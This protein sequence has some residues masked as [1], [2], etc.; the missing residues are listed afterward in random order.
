MGINPT[1]LSY[2]KQSNMSSIDI[3]SLIASRLEDMA[4]QV[5]YLHSQG[6]FHDAELLRAEGLAL[7]ESFDAGT[8]FLFINDLTE[9]A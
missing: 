2:D 5:E 7:A 4:D 9:A 8:T 6:N 3:Q 1:L